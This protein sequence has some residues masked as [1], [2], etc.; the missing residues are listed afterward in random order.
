[1]NAWF[2]VETSSDKEGPQM[3]IVVS[4]PMNSGCIILLLLETTIQNL[5]VVF[6]TGTALHC[7]V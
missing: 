2:D 6:E 1:M 3:L 4:Y 7:L 5:H